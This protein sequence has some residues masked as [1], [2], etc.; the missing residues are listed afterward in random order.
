MVGGQMSS[1]ATGR[2]L[3][4]IDADVLGRHRTGDETYI[5]QL[6]AEMPRQAPDLRV[7]AITRHPELVP[8]GVEA[9]ALP[10]RSQVIRMGLRLGRVITRLHPGLAHFQYVAPPGWRGRTVITIHDLSFEHQP[11][12]FGL[13][14]RLQLRA[15]VP[16]AARRADHVLTVSEWTRR[17]L[18]DRYG[19]RPE[20]V[21]AIYNGVSPVFTPD[22]H[23]PDRPPYLLF[24]S[25]LQP[26]KDP[27]AAV[28]ALSLLG[29]GLD[30]VFVGPDRG[31][32][33]D[34]LHAASRLRLEERIEV[35]GHISDDELAALFRGAECYVLPSKWE[36]FGLTIVEAMASGTPVVTTTAAALPEIAG[37]AAVLVPPGDPAALAEGVRSAL[38]DRE[39]LVA[40]G[41]KRAAEFSW[42]EATARTADV[43]RRLL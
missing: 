12:L 20:S 28:D 25:S 41:L 17:D 19:L 42:P 29:P 43:Y 23:R 21:T 40:A 18:I 4:A 27:V 31:S 26:R 6:L 36:G 2:P 34:I 8:A 15:L 37:D 39:R 24:V 10:A 32:R 38:A 30:L 7:V 5:A 35:K 14:A 16:R 1:P 13:Q 3:V 11:E 22:G 9:I 33:E